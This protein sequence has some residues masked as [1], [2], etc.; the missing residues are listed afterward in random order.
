MVIPASRRKF[1]NRVNDLRHDRESMQREETVWPTAK[2]VSMWVSGVLAGV[3]HTNAVALTSETRAA[4]AQWGLV[5]NRRHSSEGRA[6]SACSDFAFLWLSPLYVRER[7]V[8]IT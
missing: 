8:T 6:L 2:E 3:T 1:K 4:M 7:C 5:C